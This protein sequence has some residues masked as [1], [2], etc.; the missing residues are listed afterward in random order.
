MDSGEPDGGLGVAE[1]G[2]DGGE[3]FV[4]NAGAVV[5]GI[6]FGDFLPPVGDDEADEGSGACDGGEDQLEDADA[7]VQGHRLG[8]AVWGAV[9]ISHEMRVRMASPD[10]AATMPAVMALRMS[11]MRSSFG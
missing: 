6:G 10:R 2:G 3:A 8:G 11:H 4:V 5:G 1:L 9:R 7:V